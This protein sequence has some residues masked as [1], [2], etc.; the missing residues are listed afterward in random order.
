MK[1][2]NSIACALAAALDL[3]TAAGTSV[4]RRRQ[5]AAAQ[6]NSRTSAT[7]SADRS[8]G[9]KEPPKAEL[10]SPLK[11]TITPGQNGPRD[12]YDELTFFVEMENIGN[13]DI[14]LQLRLPPRVAMT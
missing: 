2:R 10:N 14:T 9:A 6:G 8:R 12:I 11:V 3:A 5:F 13:E 7:V 1:T 4:S